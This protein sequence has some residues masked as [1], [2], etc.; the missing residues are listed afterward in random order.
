LARPPFR[1]GQAA[2]KN[3]PVA[4]NGAK[5]NWIPA[6]HFRGDKY[7]LWCK[8]GH[9]FRRNDRL[10]PSSCRRRLNKT[11]VGLLTLLSRR[12]RFGLC[13]VLELA[14][15]TGPGANRGSVNLSR[16]IYGQGLRC[17]IA[18]S[19]RCWY[20]SRQSCRQRLYG[21]PLPSPIQAHIQNSPRHR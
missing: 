17:I 8:L 7:H 14:P 6:T 18:S 15:G 21:R 19:I 16:P 4:S 11:I 20:G 13:F 1:L 3:A 9:K 2:I 12:L 5:E 10:G